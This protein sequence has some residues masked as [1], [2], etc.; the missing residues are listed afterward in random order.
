MPKSNL[1][2]SVDFAPD[3]TRVDQE[4]IDSQYLKLLQKLEAIISKIKERRIDH[5]AL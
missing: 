4:Q 1:L 5:S 2:K 3:S